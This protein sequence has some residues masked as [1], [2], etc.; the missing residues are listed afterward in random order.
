MTFEELVDRAQAGDSEA[1]LTLFEKYRPLTAAHS[2]GGDGCFDPDLWQDQC[3]R[4][5]IVLQKFNKERALGEAAEKHPTAPGKQDG[6]PSQP[7]RK[8]T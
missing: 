4:F 1:M 2:F 3:H 7:D 5:L 8:D 6:I